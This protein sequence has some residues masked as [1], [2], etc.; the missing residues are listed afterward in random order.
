KVL[1]KYSVNATWNHLEAA[2]E[3]GDIETLLVA[4]PENQMVFPEI[5]AK[6]KQFSK[7]KNLVWMMSGKNETL[8]SLGGNVYLIPMKSYVEKEGTFINFAGLE[9]KFKKV[10]TV[11]SEALTLTEACLLMSG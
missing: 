4:G 9:Q 1:E 7:A 11:V 3:K 2:L 6:V 5:D 8:E 10:T